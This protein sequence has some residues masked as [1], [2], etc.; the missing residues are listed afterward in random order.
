M[1]RIESFVRTDKTGIVVDAIKKAGA[2]GLTV[3]S[4]KGQGEGERPI[5]GVSRGTKRQV[6][7]YNEIDSIVTIVDDSKVDAVVTAIVSAA[8]TG[9]KGDGK[10]FVSTIDVVDIGT[11]QKGSTAL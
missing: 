10:I 8:G 2:K 4:A 3:F 9:S 11:S 7:E 6:V 5:V 1:K